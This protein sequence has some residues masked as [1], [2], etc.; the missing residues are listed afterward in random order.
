MVAGSFFKKNLPVEFYALRKDYYDM[1]T[2]T[3]PENLIWQHLGAE[4]VFTQ[5]RSGKYLSFYWQAAEDYG[6]K[7]EE[8]VKSPL[9]KTI[10]P[11]N[12][13][14]YC[15]IIKKIIEQK[16]PEKCYCLFEYQERVFLFELIVSPILNQE[17]Y[18]NSVFAIGHQKSEKE[19]EIFRKNSIKTISPDFYRN[20]QLQISD[21]IFRSFEIET[22]WQNTVAQLGEAMGVDRCSILSYNLEKKLFKVEEEYCQKPFK[23]ILG[24]QFSLDSQPHLKQALECDKPIAVEIL[25]DD[26]YQQK[27]VLAIS[28]RDLDRIN[29]L[30]DLQQCDRHRNWSYLEIQFLQELA[31]RLGFA[32]GQVK[33]CQ[34]LKQA[35]I[36]A[37]EASKLKTNFLT[38]TTHELRTPL[39]GIIGFLKLIV[40]EMTDSP[41]EQREFIEEAYNS[42]LYLLDLINDILDIAKIEANKL[43]LDLNSVD[44]AE[45]LNNV[46]NF[47][48]PQAQA[49]NLSFKIKRPSNLTPIVLYSNYQRLLQVML[50][51]VGNAIKFTQEGGIL[52]NA[53]VRKKKI[54]YQAREFPGIVKI[55]VADTGI[56]VSLD[57]QEK[58]FE[59]FFQVDGSRT[60]SYGGTGLGLGI[61]QK[62][63]AAMG[64]EISF[65]SMGE[66]LG[67]TV[68]FS[69]PLHHLPVM[70]T[71]RSSSDSVEMTVDL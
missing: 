10:A 35:K 33:L 38:S 53:E 6:L 31:D 21:R 29:C 12:I 39:T 45:L 66:G 37:E 8:V 34:E 54:L 20:L 2:D 40:D 3:A 36:E 51:L 52:I 41:E 7:N 22:I 17:G 24:C 15:Q 58:L 63:V 50:N 18:A 32:I 68:T 23:S 62:L 57:K 67:S 46:E 25:S 11:K 43:E 14:D 4:L 47:T 28:I 49:K 13:A 1:K 56:G 26:E 5:E 30:I 55:S 44:L 9:E 64:G 70:E 71:L 42:A 16:T 61:S 27:S 59:N 19:T 65:Y 69:I 60:K 48:R